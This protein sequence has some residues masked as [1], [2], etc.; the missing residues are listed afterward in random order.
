MSN[1]VNKK[2]VK[3]KKKKEKKIEGKI[4]DNYYT[5]LN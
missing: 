4:E 2:L 3:L 1:L 5:K